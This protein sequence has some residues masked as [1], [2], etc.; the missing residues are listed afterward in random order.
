MGRAH[1]HELLKQ[2]INQSGALPR[3]TVVVYHQNTVSVLVFQTSFCREPV[4][5]TGCLTANLMVMQLF[6]SLTQTDNS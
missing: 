1:T 4:V 3:S 6:S 2:N 5:A